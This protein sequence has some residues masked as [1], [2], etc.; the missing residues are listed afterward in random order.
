MKISFH[1]A[2]R[3][4]TGSKHLLTLDDGQQVLLDCGMFQGLGRETES[5]NADFGFD[6]RDVSAL[7]LSHAHIDHSGL[8]PKL[9]KEGFQ[10]KIYCTPATRELTEILLHDSAEIQTYEAE[11]LN[12]KRAATHLAPY[13]PLYTTAD[14]DEAMKHFVTVDDE[15]WFDL[16]GQVS[17]FFTHTGH[18]I[19]SAAIS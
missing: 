8:I 17:F 14:V 15:Q 19:G 3:T 11:P 5:L 7:L 1:G 6:A 12:K 16:S 4:V 2:A 9:V 10:G 13:D 18:L